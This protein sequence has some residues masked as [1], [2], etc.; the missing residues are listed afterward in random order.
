[1]GTAKIGRPRPLS[2]QRRADALYTLICEEPIT[3]RWDGTA[4]EISLLVALGAVV[5]PAEHFAV[6]EVRGPTLRPCGYVI[7]VHLL[8]WPDLRLVRVTPC[9]TQ[10]A[11]RYVGGP[12]L[13]GLALVCESLHVLIKKPDREKLRLRLTAEDILED[14][15][16]VL[17]CRVVKMSLSKKRK[18]FA[19]R[20]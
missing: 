5:A 20:F 3:P 9:S 10:R 13:V 16:A 6:V 18:S 8:R 14:A 12:S 1:M 4:E 7:R 15:S 17:D 2:G 11:V 19:A